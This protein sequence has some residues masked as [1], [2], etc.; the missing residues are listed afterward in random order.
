MNLRTAGSLKHIIHNLSTA[1]GPS[2]LIGSTTPTSV[3]RNS[4]KDT[5]SVVT[6][7]NRGLGLEF[8]RQLLQRQ[9]GTVFA[10]CR[11]PKAAHELQQLAEHYGS[12]LEVRPLDLRDQQSTTRLG[13][14]I[15]GTR[16]RVDLLLNVAAVLHHPEVP[17]APERCLGHL[18]R[19]WLRESLEVNTIGPLMLTQALEPA[20]RTKG[21]DRPTSVVANLSARV[22][23]V[24]D[25][26]LGGWYSYR[27]CKT[28]LNMGTKNLSIELKR[29]G[30]WVVSLH[31]GT[32]ETGLSKPFQKNVKPNKLF[33]A[34]FSVAQLLG[35]VDALDEEHTGGFFSWDGSRIEW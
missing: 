31:P 6:G 33:S 34:E 27:M 32:V 19:A 3:L 12:R 7:A 1:S 4:S 17:K 29:L 25:N 15:C 5:V 28:A 9:H 20:L 14:E 2:V 23:S 26:Q 22:G 18:D 21:S 16:Q 10:C 24:Q 30:V 11:D 13:E 8:T 35:V